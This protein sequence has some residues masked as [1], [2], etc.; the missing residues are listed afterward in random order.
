MT[1]QPNTTR[2]SFNDVMK[3]VFDIP[4]PDHVPNQSGLEMSQAREARAE[5]I[6]VGLEKMGWTVEEACAEAKKPEN[7]KVIAECLK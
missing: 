3:F 2:C 6:R 1:T 5:Y 4:A 7:F